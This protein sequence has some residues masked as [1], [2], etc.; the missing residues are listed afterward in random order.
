M[1]DT[2]TYQE[3]LRTLGALLDADGCALGVLRVSRQEAE[4][5]AP[6]W[7]G[8]WTW[9]AE[10]LR[11]AAARQC[12]ARG[13]RRPPSQGPR[14]WGPI[15]RVLGAQLDTLAG[16]R[17]V[18]TLRPAAVLVQS[19]DHEQ[20]FERTALERRAQLLPYLRAQ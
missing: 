17:Y 20:L 19:G 15:L 5:M 3:M 12:A 18:L 16:S 6:G 13:L 1:S 8:A 11:A 4:I 2:L 7:R 10:A 14:R 9:T